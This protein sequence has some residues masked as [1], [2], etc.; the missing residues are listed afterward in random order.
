MM[1]IKVT[2]ESL[3]TLTISRPDEELGLDDMRDIFTAIM[4]YLTWT[5]EQV[6]ELFN[7]TES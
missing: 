3:G 2:T 7:D 1:K 4:R 6:K 5:D